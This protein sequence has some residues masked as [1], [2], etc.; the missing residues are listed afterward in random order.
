MIMIT[1]TIITIISQI[2]KRLELHL[3]E[4]QRDDFISILKI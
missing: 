1:T 2:K 3:W 4:T